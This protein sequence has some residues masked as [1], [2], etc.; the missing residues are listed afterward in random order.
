MKNI[1]EAQCH[2]CYGH[3]GWPCWKPR[4]CLHI[5]P[6]GDVFLLLS[7]LV[8]LFAVSFIVI[9]QNNPGRITIGRDKP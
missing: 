8:S 1:E 9:M 6:T 5:L 4:R 2:T 3:A 7:L